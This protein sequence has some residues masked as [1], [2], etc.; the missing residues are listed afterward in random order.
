MRKITIVL[1]LFSCSFAKQ[2]RGLYL[3]KLNVESF[4]ITFLD[5]GESYS[6]KDQDL[7]H[8]FIDNYIN[9]NE[10]YNV[11]FKAKAKVKVNYKDSEELLLCDNLYFKYKGKTYKSNAQLGDFWDKLVLTESP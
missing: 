4:E 6:L 8:D 9:Q 5:K 1:F 2:E 7:M 3:D 10:E 11:K